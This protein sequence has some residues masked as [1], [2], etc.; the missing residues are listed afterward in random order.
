[1]QRRV[2]L[3]CFTDVEEGVVAGPLRHVGKAR[4]DVMAGD[5]LA[6]PGDAPRV[7]AYEAGEAEQ[8]CCFASAGPTD[9]SDD[10]AVMDVE[11]DFPKSGNRDAARAIVKGFAQRSDGKND[12]LHAILRG[13]A[14]I[15]SCKPPPSQQSL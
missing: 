3:E 8:Q 10:L 13:R 11:R 6:E 4:R 14:R 15:Q 5:L 7:R 12:A 2:V 9:E 1:M